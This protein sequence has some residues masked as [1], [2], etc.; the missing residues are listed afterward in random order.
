MAHEI[1]SDIL[2]KRSA[3]IRAMALQPARGVL[4][5]HFGVRRAL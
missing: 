3:A 5:P 2:E 4:E 1:D